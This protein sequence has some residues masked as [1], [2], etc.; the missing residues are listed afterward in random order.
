MQKENFPETYTPGAEPAALK[1]SNGLRRIVEF[2]GR[3][4][5]WFIMPLVLVTVLD[6]VARKLT[7]RAA[8]GSVYGLQI[9]LKTHVSRYSN[10]RCCRSSSGICTRHCSLVLGFARSI[11]RTCVS[12]SSVIT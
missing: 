2:V 4:G 1:L 7:F 3:W 8:D 11:I 5:S 10:R 9:W 6:V 12:I